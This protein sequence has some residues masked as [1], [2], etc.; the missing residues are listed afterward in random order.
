MSFLTFKTDIS[1]SNLKFV[2]LNVGGLKTKLQCPEFVEYL[3][4]FD[5]IALQE[6]KLD[7]LDVV[8]LDQY[9]CVFKHRK[10]K[11]LRKSGGLAVFVREKLYK[12][13][14]YVETECEYVLWFKLS[15]C[16]F[17]TEEDAMFGIVYIPPASSGYN[18]ES[19]LEQFN[20]E[21]DDFSR[22]YKNL[23][24]MGDF[25]NA[26]TSAMTD[27][28]ETD[29]DIY[30]HIDIDPDEVFSTDS[31]YEIGKLGFNSKRK[32]EDKISNKY[33]KTLLD[34]CKYHDL[35]ILNGR[36]FNDKNIG[37]ATCKN[38]SFVDYVI[39]SSAF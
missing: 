23:V 24:L 12:Y 25:L 18:V 8:H 17:K 3:N 10:Q 21:L 30:S 29:S 26:R 14:T 4:D 33:G 13:F 28:T 16:L 36:A 5:I 31:A 2:S 37:K 7:E 11:V 27:I 6:T 32:S 34:I 22:F 9:Q 20:I 35:I 15:K 38:S 39:S 1:G 19:I